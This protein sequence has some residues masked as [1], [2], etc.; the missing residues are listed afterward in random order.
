MVGLG[1]MGRSLVLNMA[2]H[3]FAVAGYDKDLTKGTALVNEGAG[4]PIAAAGN[5]SDFVGMLRPPRV[6][7]LLVAPAPVVDAVLRD[8]LPHLAPGDLVIDAGNSHFPDTDRRAKSLAEKGVNFFG[9]GVSGGESGARHGPSLMPGGPREGYERVRPILEAIAARVSNEPCVAWMGSGSAGHYVKMVH[10]G[11]EYGIMQ[12]LSESYD[13]MHRGLGLDDDELHAVFQRWN[14]GELN[15]FLVE[16][17]AQIFLKVD[18]RTGNRLIDVIRD[19]ARQK[20][21][22]KWTSQAALDLQTP[23]PILDVA[24]TMR[25]LSGLDQ[26]RRAAHARLGGPTPVFHGARDEF[27][28][29]LQNALSAAV[30]LTYTQGL[31]VLRHASKAHGYGLNLEE[32]ARIWRGGCIIR[33]ALLDDIRAAFRAQ[34]DLANLVLD[35][36]L[37]ERLKARQQDLRRVVGIAVEMGIPAPGLMMALSYY[38]ALRSGWLPANLIQAQ[39]DYFGAHTYERLDAEGTYHTKWEAG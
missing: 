39:R 37:A 15:S 38:D 32:V 3:G 35:P 14:Q 13:L 6:I 25:D 10:N 33:A 4:K 22:G 9:M 36:R 34:P 31:D 26:E 19:S 18:E 17:T 7:M 27:L 20:G 21:T 5:V 29:Q 23:T 24:V 1:V 16:I 12:L 8:L 2:D 28:Q 30:I 11:I